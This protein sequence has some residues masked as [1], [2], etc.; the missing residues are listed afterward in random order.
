MSKNFSE[1]RIFFC[2]ICIYKKSLIVRIGTLVFYFHKYK[3]Y[4]AE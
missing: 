4:V 1:V 3:S 2:F